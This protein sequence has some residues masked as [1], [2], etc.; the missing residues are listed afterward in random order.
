M[1]NRYVRDLHEIVSVGDVMRVWVVEVDKQRRRV[2]LTAI[3]PSAP[4]EPPR[5]PPREAR[6]PARAAAG[7]PATAG[8]AASTATDGRPAKR[9]RRPSGQKGP[10]FRGGAG[11]RGPAQREPR[12]HSRS[13][14]PRPATPI[15]KEMEEGTAPLRSFSD[16]MQF[17]E[18]KHTP[19]DTKDG[20]S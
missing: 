10:H 5:R 12:T 19:E 7:A 15:T 8:S 16:L 9:E 2:S 11:Q 18:K 4:P 13:S 1:A 14:K 3:D 20:E 17:W 6:R